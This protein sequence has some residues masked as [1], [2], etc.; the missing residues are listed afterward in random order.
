VVPRSTLE[1]TTE[2]REG[3]TNPRERVV[4]DGEGR[5]VF[6]GEAHEV[7]VERPRV[8]APG[9]INREATEPAKGRP[10][11]IEPP[12]EDEGEGENETPELR[13]VN[14]GLLENM[15]YRDLQAAANDFD[16]ISGTLSK[17]EFVDAFSGMGY[18]RFG[19]A[20]EN[21]DA[22]FPVNEEGV[23]VD[24]PDDRGPPSDV[25]GG[26][27]GGEGNNDEQEGPPSDDLP[28]DAGDS[29]SRE[30]RLRQAEGD[31]EVGQ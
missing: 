10:P 13:T 31:D 21:T 15:D 4:L 2:E 17:S 19:E 24:I 1:E 18:A 27:G 22:E 11:K 9:L 28:V 26:E 25:G 6:D 23:V 8:G 3:Y 14:R 29:S 5:P 30:D 7:T 16:D 12:N 20:V